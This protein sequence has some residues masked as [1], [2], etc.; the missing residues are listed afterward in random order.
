MTS[1][2]H[3]K[4]EGNGGTFLE[5]VELANVFEFVG[6]F[7]AGLFEDTD[8]GLAI[9]QEFRF[10]VEHPLD[11]HLASRRLGFMPLGS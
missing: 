8:V 9:F 1:V 3:V 2:R 7:Q 6:K 5:R 4:R 11:V 10:Q